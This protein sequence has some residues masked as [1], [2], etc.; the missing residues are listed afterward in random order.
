MAGNAVCDKPGGRFRSAL[1]QLTVLPD[2]FIKRAMG[3]SEALRISFVNLAAH[4][5][6]KLEGA[7]ASHVLALTGMVPHK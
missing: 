4:A 3:I 5:S 7:P 6:D 1:R 2:P